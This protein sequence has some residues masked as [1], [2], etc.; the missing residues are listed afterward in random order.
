MEGKCRL[1]CLEDVILSAMLLTLYG[2]IIGNTVPRKVYV[3]YVV[4]Q[5][6]ILEICGTEKELFWDN[7]LNYKGLRDG[8]YLLLLWEEMNELIY[9]LSMV[10]YHDD[11]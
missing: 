5:C 6:T 9:I 4:E 8:K 11:R 1:D 10:V 3:N 2:E 7:I